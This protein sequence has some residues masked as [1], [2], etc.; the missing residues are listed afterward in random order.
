MLKPKDRRTA[1]DAWRR[2][3]LGPAEGAWQAKIARHGVALE[4]IS[5]R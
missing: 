1:R 5:A 3:D 2:K 4:R